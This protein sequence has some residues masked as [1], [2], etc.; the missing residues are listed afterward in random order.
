MVSPVL[1]PQTGVQSKAGQIWQGSSRLQHTI[2]EPNWRLMRPSEGTA[3]LCLRKFPSLTDAGS[4]LA[5]PTGDQGSCCF[6]V[7][8]GICFLSVNRTP[9]RADK[10]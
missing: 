8:L 9:L 10:K 1:C 4:H 7:L 6:P 3:Y 5:H 2:G